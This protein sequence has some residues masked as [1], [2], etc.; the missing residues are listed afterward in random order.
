MLQRRSGGSLATTLERFAKAIR[1][2]HAYRRQLRVATASSRWA[3][4]VIVTASLGMLIYLFGWQPEYINQF[5]DSRMGQVVFATA[6]VLQAV[7]VLWV[8]SL[9]QAE[10]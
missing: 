2:R 9:T 6:L 8:L 1:E 10:V 3:A 7:G 5:L 4:I